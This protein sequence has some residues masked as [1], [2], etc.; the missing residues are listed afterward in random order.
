MTDRK[1]PYLASPDWAWVNTPVDT[2]LLYRLEIERGRAEIAVGLMAVMANMALDFTPVVGDI[3]GAVEAAV[4]YNLLGDKLS[5]GE[6]VLSVATILPFGDFLR[7]GKVADDL[8]DLRKVG[9][10]LDEVDD[11]AR[12]GRHL[13]DG[14]PPP[15]GSHV[16]ADPPPPPDPPGTRTRFL[17][18]RMEPP[19]RYSADALPASHLDEFDGMRRQ[20]EA[21]VEFR[22][23][24][25]DEKSRR[26]LTALETEQLAWAQGEV[27]RQSAAMGDKA[28]EIF[29]HAEY[30][31][32]AR[33]Y[34][35]TS[36]AASRS[37]NFD[38]VYKAKIGDDE[39]LVVVEAKGGGMG[40]GSVGERTVDGVKH[41]QGTR[42]Y[43]EDIANDMIAYGER[44][45]DTHTAQTGRD[46]LDALENENVRYHRVQ[47]HLGAD[48][49][50]THIEARQFYVNELPR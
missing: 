39:V 50:L 13:D 42:A 19:V 28:G 36:D 47:A 24:L 14:V 30:A 4:G 17:D 34:P 32:A 20:R 41:Q 44:H 16:G 26:E 23:T 48:G 8:A 18:E 25:L 33:V 35:F 11:I 27:R 10:S 15:G 1:L 40:S 6:R 5:V 46:L 45:G 9:R 43:Y 7:L 49:A 2:N 31:D 3:K 22:D 37:G 38:Q 21:A 12:G 29:A